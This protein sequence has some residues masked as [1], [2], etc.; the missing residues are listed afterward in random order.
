MKTRMTLEM[1]HELE[2]VLAKLNAGYKV[3]FDN[4]LDANEM[5]IHIDTIGVLLSNNSTT[6][7]NQSD[8]NIDIVVDK[9]A[10]YFEKETNWLALRSC[11]L[12]NDRSED[13]RKLLK[14]ALEE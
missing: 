1:W 7:N 9:I 3:D 8:A 12:N 14:K 5:I 2:P 11:W 13:L 10:G 4:H 6:T